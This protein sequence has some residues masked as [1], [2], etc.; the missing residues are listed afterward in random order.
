MARQSTV[1]KTFSSFRATYRVLTRVW[2][3]VRVRVGVGEMALSSRLTCK[4]VC[5]HMLRT[6]TCNAICIHMLRVRAG[7]R[8]PSLAPRCSVQHR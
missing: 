2:V 8:S 4:A 3:T 6:L 5:I 1:L 7:V